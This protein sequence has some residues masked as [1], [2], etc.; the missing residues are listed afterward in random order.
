MH[1]GIFWFKFD[2]FHTFHL[3]SL[4]WSCHILYTTV[5][6][7]S[8]HEQ[9]HRDNRDHVIMSEYY[10]RNES[11]PKSPENGKSKIYILAPEKAE[12]TVVSVNSDK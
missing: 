5:C 10:V 4:E 8:H 7:Y 1:L 2:H 3:Y 11:R 6:H 12:H 9:P